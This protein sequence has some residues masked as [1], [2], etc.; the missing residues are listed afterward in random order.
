MMSKEIAKKLGSVDGYVS[1][2]LRIGAERM[3]TTLEALRAKRKKPSIDPSRV[4]RYHRIAD[5][6]KKLWWDD[7][8]PA[9]VVARRLACGEGT[10][11]LAIRFWFESRGHAI[12][13][14]GDW[15]ERLAGRVVQLFDANEL[16]IKEIG[17]A[18]HLGRTRI[19]EIVREAYRRLGRDLPDGRT[20]L[21]GLKQDRSSP[22]NSSG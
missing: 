2:L 1:R 19:M 12:P 7:L 11:K 4:P 9:A 21:A 17:V 18:V 8:F 16:P 14:F 20:R 13:T 10:V 3:G 22:G 15:S 5:D 6:A